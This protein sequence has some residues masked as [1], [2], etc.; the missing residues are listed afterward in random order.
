MFTGKRPTDK[1][2]KDGLNLHNFVKMAIP[3]RLVQIVD[4]TLIAIVKETVPAATEN[5]VND[6]E[7]CYTN[8]IE[9]EEENE[10]L[11]KMNAVWKCLLL[12]L[13]IGLAC[14]EESPKNRI[15][16]EDVIKELHH[17]QTTFIGVEIVMISLLWWRMQ[18]K[19]VSHV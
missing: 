10:N 7:T 17:I 1:M 4:P 19:R 11:S 2:F 18:V 3:G 16:M 13:K 6:M 5:E 9:A 15:C 14:S 8:E 12:I